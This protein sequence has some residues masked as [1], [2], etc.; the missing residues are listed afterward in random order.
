M[1]VSIVINNYNYA[2][3][4][5]AA[6]DSALMQTWRPLEVVVVD[7]GST[8]DSWSIIE[9]Y[10]DRVHALRQP[11]GGQ[12]AA[13]NSG[14][15]ASRG[16]WVLFLDS[17]DLLDADAVERMLKHAQPEVSK[18]QGPLRHI[19]SEGQS[20]GGMVPYLTHDGDVRPIARRFR[21]Y[22]G[23]PASGNLYRR[24]AIAPYFPLHAPSWQ[25]SADTVPNLLS[26]FHGRVAT[27]REPIGCYR[28]HTQGNQRFGL[29]GN[30]DRSFAAALRQSDD[31]RRAAESWGTRCTGIVWPGGWHT[32]P[33][34]WRARVLSWRLQRSE[35]PYPHDTRRSIWRGLNES[36]AQ[37]PGYTAIERG[38]QRAWV[39][40]MLLA[41]LRCVT[42]LAPSNVSGGLRAGFK[43][44][45]RSSP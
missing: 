19:G 28:L 43:R 21:Q 7:D 8:D 33:W 26:V 10:R 37:W 2:R 22:A 15:A 35:H 17:D 3:Y 38:V 31:R 1:L 30:L 24:S 29:F 20:L 11:N 27:V 6:I 18:V 23:P 44:L 4:L 32:L 14:F 40:V 16:E 13:Y 42:A 5:G 25:R 39:A 34:E 41:P 45:R 12:G 36:L 9:R